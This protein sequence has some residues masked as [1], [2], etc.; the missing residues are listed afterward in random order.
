MFLYKAPSTVGN[1]RD[2][3]TK[4][5]CGALEVKSRE[6][7]SES[8]LVVGMQTVLAKVV[9][10]FTITFPFHCIT[11]DCYNGVWLLTS[12]HVCQ[13]LHIKS[14][15]LPVPAILIFFKFVNNLYFAGKI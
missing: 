10:A 11:S 4:L 5:I 6:S 1:E 13:G 7:Y 9:M 15:T 12:L 14:V 8:L 2:N 3:D